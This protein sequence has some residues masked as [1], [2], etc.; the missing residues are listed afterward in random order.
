MELSMF[1]QSSYRQKKNQTQLVAQEMGPTSNAECVSVEHVLNW[2]T[3]IIP[4]EILKEKFTDK[5]CR[6]ALEV[7]QRPE[8]SS[9]WLRELNAH[10]KDKNTNIYQ[11]QTTTSK[12]GL[13]SKQSVPK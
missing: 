10:R 6:V 2:S 5:Q 12:S 4:K 7:I 11:A 13:Y 3:Y 1:L 8:L 9:Q